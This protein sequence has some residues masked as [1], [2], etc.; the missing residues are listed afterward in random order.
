[1]PNDYTDQF[2]AARRAMGLRE[3][4][5]KIF[6]LHE[7][8]RCGCG[9]YVT[10]ATANGVVIDHDDNC[11]IRMMSSRRTTL[12]LDGASNICVSVWG[13]E[14]LQACALWYPDNGL[15]PYERA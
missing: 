11:S 10:N 3:T 9:C 12:R 1:M 2:N 6:D 8:H 5:A 4:T 13:Y 14:P 15:F 7:G